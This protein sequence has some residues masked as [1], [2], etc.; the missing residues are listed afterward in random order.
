[1]RQSRFRPA[2]YELPIGHPDGETEEGVRPLTLTLP[3]GARISVQGKVDRVDVCRENGRTYLRVVDY[4]TGSKQFDLSQ[5]AEGLNL[6]ML[7]YLMAIWEN[8]GERYGP[9][10]PAGV[11]YLPARLPLV[12]VPRDTQGEELEKAQTRAM[13]MNGLLLDDPAVIEAMEPGAAGLFIPAKK[14]AVQYIAARDRAELF[15]EWKRKS[16]RKIADNKKYRRIR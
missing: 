9:V 14:N 8:G 10:T 5:V 7:I 11:L 12:S 13:R 3:D 6:Q 4:K 2:D 16:S 1:M 15:R